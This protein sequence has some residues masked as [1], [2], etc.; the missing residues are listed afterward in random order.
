MIEERNTPNVE[1]D[2]PDWKTDTDFGPAISHLAVV[3]CGLG[4]LSAQDEHWFRA[5]LVEFYWSSYFFF[6]TYLSA[7]DNMKFSLLSE[8]GS[9]PRQ[10]S[11]NR[12]LLESPC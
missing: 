11:A 2:D 1:Y 4:N 10:G 5:R 7:T 8:C 3:Q 6:F 12:T 9:S